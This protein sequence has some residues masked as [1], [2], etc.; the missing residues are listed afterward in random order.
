MHTSGQTYKELAIPYFRET[1]DIIDEV[2]QAVGIP[3]YLIGAS[4]IALELLKAGIKPGRGTKDIDFA[5]MIAGRKE[6]EQITSALEARGFNKVAAPWTF[7]SAAFRVAI[8]VLPFGEITE[9]HTDNFH[10]RHTDLHVLGLREVLEDAVPVSIEEKIVNIPPLPGMAILKLIAWS[11]RPEERVDDLFDLLRIMQY[12]YDLKWDEI[13]EVHFDALEKEP[14]DP[15][16]I[17]AEV[18]GRDAAIYL[19]RSS[20][21]ASR[22]IQVLETNLEDA[23][24]SSIARAWARA[25]DKNIEY[26]YAL[27]DAFRAGIMYRQ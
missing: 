14:L 5:V 27:L 16:L 10:E 25:L 13:V 20:A 19:Q 15:L 22:I 17:S 18:L 26:A 8:D 7:Y 23:S 3:Y 11:D 24:A 12:Y 21:I 4:A 6:Y 1:F 9:N 2:M